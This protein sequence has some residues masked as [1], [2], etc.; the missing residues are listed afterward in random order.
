M[1]MWRKSI[2]S[3]EKDKWNV[4]EARICLS[5]LR[6]R[7]T[8]VTGMQRARG[9]VVGEEAYQEGRACLQCSEEKGRCPHS[10]PHT[11]TNP[12]PG[13]ES[14][15]FHKASQQRSVLP[16]FLFHC[17]S[18]HFY[19]KSLHRTH[20]SKGFLP[21]LWPSLLLYGCPFWSHPTFQ[22]SENCQPNISK[23]V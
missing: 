1:R 4:S 20:L 18:Y 16:E 17:A 23:K 15:F 9:K 13:S 11:A 3:R 2:P 6:N 19:Q 7:D 8:G 12:V 5:H 10:S 14:L 21:Y 22:I